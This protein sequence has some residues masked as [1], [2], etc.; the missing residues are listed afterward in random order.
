MDKCDFGTGRPVSPLQSA[1][2]P[3]NSET[4]NH[5]TFSLP[6]L[7]QNLMLGLVKLAFTLPSAPKTAT[8]RTE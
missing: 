2:I 3:L 7:H 5:F 8:A 4:E 1:V 6:F